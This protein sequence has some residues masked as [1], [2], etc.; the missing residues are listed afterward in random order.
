M[1]AL[2][3][4]IQLSA[5]HLWGVDCHKVCCVLDCKFVAASFVSVLHPLSA[6]AVQKL[7]RC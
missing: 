7:Q 6:L 5:S 3:N 4:D 2:F 1:Q